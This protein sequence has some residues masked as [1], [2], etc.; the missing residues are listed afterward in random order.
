[1]ASSAWLTASTPTTTSATVPAERPVTDTRRRRRHGSGE[2]EA[3]SS[4]PTA[5]PV[6]L[7]STARVS[8]AGDAIRLSRL[9]AKPSTPDPGADIR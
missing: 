7:T 6:A 1:V 8:P 5:R 9:A 4:A 3:A 2:S